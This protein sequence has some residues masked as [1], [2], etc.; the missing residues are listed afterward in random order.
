MTTHWIGTRQEWLAA[1]TTLLEA[2]T[3]N[4]D[5][6]TQQRQELP[7]VPIDRAYRF[8]TD[9]GTASLEDLFKGRSQL[10]MYHFMYGPDYHAGCSSFSMIADG[11]NGFTVHLARHD[12]MLWAVSRAPLAKLR[13]YKQRMGWSF[14]W[15]SSHSSDVNADFNVFFTEDQQREGIDYNYR[16][17]PVTEWRAGKE[18]GG[19]STETKFATMCETDAAT[20]HRDRPGLSAFAREDGAFYHTYSTYARG[21][22]A[23]WGMYQWLDRAPKGHNETGGVWWRRHD[24]YGAAGK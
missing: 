23:I 20:Y 6:L 13:A 22:D 2:L 17:E 18:G 19:G 14:P 3:R 24:E 9:E 4:S 10:L 7:W 15:A 21:V 11:F 5:A 12:V 8:D 16:R 1:R